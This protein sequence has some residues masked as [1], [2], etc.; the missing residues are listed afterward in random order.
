MDE[1]R[2]LQLIHQILLRAGGGNA[3]LV[4]DEFLEILKRDGAPSSCIDL[5]EKAKNNVP[6]AYSFARDYETLTPEDLEVAK[7]RGDARRIREA[8]EAT[9]GRC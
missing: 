5:V 9:R 8:E 2:V 3:R 1:K 7:Q 6:E 4:L